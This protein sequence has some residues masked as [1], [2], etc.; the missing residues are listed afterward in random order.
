M[1]SKV[2]L[3]VSNFD[4]DPDAISKSIGVKPSYL[5][6]KGDIIKRPRRKIVCD[7]NFWEYSSE[8]DS[9][10][11][12][13]DHMNSILKILRDHQDYFYEINNKAELE[14]GIV[15]NIQDDVNIGFHLDAQVIQ[16]LGKLGIEIDCD[17]YITK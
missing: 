9:Q 8:N 11:P 10:S 5:I 3:R 14:L 1:E 6:R 13:E 15:S 16:L 12:I 17:L 2:V 4:F 7:Y